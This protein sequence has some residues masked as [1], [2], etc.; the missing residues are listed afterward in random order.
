MG[1]QPLNKPIVGMTAPDSGGYWMVASDGGIF[2]FGDAQFHGSMGG[3]PLNKPIVAMAATPGG[4]YWTV[5]SDGGIFAF[6]AP[7]EGS[8]GGGSLGDPVVGMVATP[9]GDGY[10]LATAGG[11]VLSYGDATMTGPLGVFPLSGSVVAITAP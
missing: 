9:D 8:A 6:D 3:Q 11:N 2:A 5:A 10:S 7:F 1:G 4:G